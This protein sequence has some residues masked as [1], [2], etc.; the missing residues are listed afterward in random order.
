MSSRRYPS[1][2]R[3]TSVY[4]PSLARRLRASCLHWYQ[5]RP[6]LVLLSS[7]GPLSACISS[8]RHATCL[9]WGVSGRSRR[10]PWRRR[11]ADSAVSTPAAAS[12]RTA[13]A[14]SRLALRGV[15]LG[16]RL[17]G[18][19]LRLVDRRRL[20]IGVGTGAVVSL[21]RPAESPLGIGQGAHS[22]AARRGPSVLL[23]SF[24][25]LLRRSALGGSARTS[26]TPS[27]FFAF[28]GF[29]FRSRWSFARRPRRAVRDRRTGRRRPS[30]RRRAGR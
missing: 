6:A 10:R 3:P 30:R 5:Q 1:S 22:L 21:H 2:C 26:S 8:V 7:C 25:R 15:E 18:C 28:A 23:R 17:V 12:S 27:D 4:R 13:S 20:A 24:L 19:R 9:A 11:R 16:D 29:A 14:A